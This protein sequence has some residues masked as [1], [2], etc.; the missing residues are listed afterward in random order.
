MISNSGNMR[1]EAYYESID[2]NATD[3]SSVFDLDLRE[4]VELTNLDELIEDMID[5]EINIEEIPDKFGPDVHYFVDN[6]VFEIDSINFTEMEV[7]GNYQ[8]LT[9]EYKQKTAYRSKR[10]WSSDVCSSD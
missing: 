8:E 6:D 10:D 3:H 5:K 9:F 7:E 2:F 1:N 4:D